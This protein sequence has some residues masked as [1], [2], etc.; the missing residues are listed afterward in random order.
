[1]NETEIDLPRFDTS[2]LTPF[3]YN[4]SETRRVVNSYGTKGTC[5]GWLMLN[6][7]FAVVVKY[8]HTDELCVYPDGYQRNHKPYLYEEPTS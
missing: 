7:C 6:N 1:M 3:R 4:S 5:C 2:K 8:D